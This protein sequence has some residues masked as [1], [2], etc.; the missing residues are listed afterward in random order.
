MKSQI[1]PENALESWI[2]YLQRQGKSDHTIAA[3]RRAIEHFAMWNVSVTHAPL[4]LSTVIPRDVRDWKAWQQT[5]EKTSPATINQRLVGV[6]RFFAWAISEGLAREDPTA[7]IAT[8]RL[9]PRQPKGIAEAHL[10]Q[11]L[12]KAHG[13]PRDSAIIEVLAG[14]GLRVSE[15]LALRVG[16]LV[17]S[18][19]SGRIIV[20]QSKH[21]SYREVPLT[22]DVRKALE[23]YLAVHPQKDDPNA[24]LWIGTRG[25]LIHRT[26]I[27]RILNSYAV[28]AGIDELNPHALRH[29]FAARYLKANPGDLRGLARL[30][31]HT[32]VNTVMIYTEPDMDDLTERMERMESRG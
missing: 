5:V 24:P 2:G 17:M 27:A 32:N 18:E 25:P 30:L 31:G 20:R 19:R 1:V 3:Y 21:G 9:P 7:G 26:S 4:E 16:D 6:S 14:T 11:I 8:L 23:A 13:D 29:T 15:F 28:L 22:I 12:R 10:R